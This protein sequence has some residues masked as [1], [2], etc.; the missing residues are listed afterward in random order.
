MLRMRAIQSLILFAI[1]IGLSLGAAALA[2]AQPVD[3]PTLP[4]ARIVRFPGKEPMGKYRFVDWAI[5]DHYWRHRLEYDE[6]RDGDAPDAPLGEVRVPPGQGL[7]LWLDYS[8]P[9]ANFGNEWYPYKKS[10]PP[11]LSI[12]S[13]FQ[14]DD[15]QALSLNSLKFQDHE[16]AYVGRLTGIKVLNLFHT[17]TIDEDLP[18]LK[19]LSALNYLNLSCT[20]ITN[21]GLAALQGFKALTGLEISA[22]DQITDE[23]L[24]A[25][26][27][28]PQLKH[29]GIMGRQFSDAGMAH[30]KNMT[31]LESLE[32]GGGVSDAGLACLAGLQNLKELRLGG[33]GFRDAGLAH[34]APLGQLR[35]LWL[36]TIGDAGIR[37]LARLPALETL[38][39]TD[40]QVSPACIADFTRMRALKT[41]R[42][43]CFYADEQHRDD[44]PR[45][46]TFLKAL[47]AALP[48]CR[49]IQ[50]S[51]LD[52]D[53]GTAYPPPDWRPAIDARYSLR[54]GEVLKRV[55]ITENGFNYERTQFV[56]QQEPK[57]QGGVYWPILLYKMKNE[58]HWLL[59]KGFRTGSLASLIRTVGTIQSY[60]ILGSPDVLDLQINTSNPSD[61]VIDADSSTTLRLEAL[62]KY[63]REHA[64]V[65][66][67][68]G[69]QNKEREVIVI[70]GSLSLYEGLNHSR[71]I[72]PSRLVRPVIKLALSDVK[73]S[74]PRMMKNFTFGSLHSAIKALTSDP[75]IN[76]TGN[77]SDE[78]FDLESTIPPDAFGEQV[79]PAVRQARLK[80]L[81]DN[82]ARLTGLQYRV[83]T[84]KMETWDVT[85]Q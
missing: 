5:L 82:L 29:L 43:S 81:L 12:L 32:L 17:N 22:C 64:G 15:I 71:E 48:E 2:L 14:P 6:Y 63:L 3:G 79:D 23:G 7:M 26:A 41:F 9:A 42:F 35:R 83:E 1:L 8:S 25:L 77:S 85:R 38:Y 30:L 84:R 56:K 70:S 51:I 45:K 62:T 49:I 16:M 65:K 72:V 57:F 31:G 67:Q 39:I 53:P 50:G 68:I 59:D 47:H 44:L 37:Q 34:L 20:Q 27:G 76:Q 21:R 73:S 24:A 18:F 60:Q 19:S 54:P 74:A 69:Y 10:E 66:I 40:P 61:W 52:Y 33:V 75:V 4:T 13:S 28:M 80:E 36:T 58:W 46:D 55:P 11:R 78:H